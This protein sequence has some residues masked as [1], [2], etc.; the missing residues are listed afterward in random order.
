MIY[1]TMDKED[2]FLK[3]IREFESMCGINQQDYHTP[4]NLSAGYYPR[5]VSYGLPRSSEASDG[6]FLDTKFLKK[7]L[8]K[9]GI[10]PA[11][12]EIIENGL[13]CYMERIVKDIFS[14]FEVS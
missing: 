8:E 5:T 4:G 13:Y 2:F 10:D 12:V 9:R 7:R 6:S 1:A 3:S 11:G 14:V